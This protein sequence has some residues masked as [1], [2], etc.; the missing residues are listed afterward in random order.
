M[1]RFVA[2]SRNH[3]PVKSTIMIHHL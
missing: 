2:N 3:M 1:K